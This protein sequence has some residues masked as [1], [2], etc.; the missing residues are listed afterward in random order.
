LRRIFFEG[1]GYKPVIVSNGLEVIDQLR[2]QE[3]DI[4]F[5]DVQMPEMDGFETTKFIIHKLQI[6]F[7]PVIVAM[8]AFALEGDKE[9]CLE[10]GMNDY[11]SKPFLI[12]EIVERIRKWVPVKKAK[13]AMKRNGD[14]NQSG[15]NPS[16][17]T[18]TLEIL[19]QNTVN[20]LKQMMGEADPTF[21]RQVMQMFIAQAD[22]QLEL[23]T[24]AASANNL[25]ELGS[26]AHKLKGSAL[27]IGAD[28]MAET[29]RELELKARELN[30]TGLN[31]LTA[32]LVSEYKTTREGILKIITP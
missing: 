10:V 4:I 21:F 17:Q 7:K 18:K 22:E 28:T 5:M 2:K 31:E 6:P 27:N 19:N 8:T 15:Q 13:E 16:P 9:K 24:K 23:M 30:S 29:C 32:R 26:L 1:L 20:R 12:E 25:S 14:S 3:F 11:I